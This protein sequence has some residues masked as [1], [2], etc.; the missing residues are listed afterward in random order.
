MEVD[1]GMEQDIVENQVF[2][3]HGIEE[4]EEDDWHIISSFIENTGVTRDMQPVDFFEL[5]PQHLLA[6]IVLPEV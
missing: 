4:A 1:E 5:F 6:Y 2:E 3:D